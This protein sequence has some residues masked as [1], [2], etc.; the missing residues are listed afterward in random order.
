[1]D[2]FW[3]VGMFSLWS[4]FGWM[5]VAIAACLAFILLSQSLLSVGLLIF[6]VIAILANRRFRDKRALVNVASL[7]LASLLVSKWIIDFVRDK[8]ND[9][10]GRGRKLSIF[11]SD[12]WKNQDDATDKASFLVGRYWDFWDKLTFHPIPDGCGHLRRHR[13]H[14][15]HDIGHLYRRT[16]DCP[17]DS[18]VPLTKLAT[19]VIFAAP[20]TSVL[21][22]LTL[23]RALVIAPFLAFSA[24]SA[25][26]RFGE[27]TSIQQTGA[28][29]SELRSLGSWRGTATSTTPI[30]S[31]KPSHQD[32]S[33]TI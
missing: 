14:S 29:W 2:R 19:L 25:S 17:F 10:F 20:L 8:P 18:T 16:R 6:I 30:T 4:L 3:L 22:D 27:F 7:G 26:L 21:T 11:E 23:R 12:A 31:T 15:N 24:E 1:M 9:Y 5:A 13:R 28:S 33:D 32:Q